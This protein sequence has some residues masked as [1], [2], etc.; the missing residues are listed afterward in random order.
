MI[1]CFV[2]HRGAKRHNYIKCFTM[3]LSIRQRFVT[4]HSFLLLSMAFIIC[5]ATLSRGI[6]QNRPLPFAIL[7]STNPGRISV[8]VMADFFALAC[9]DLV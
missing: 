8:T 7:V 4:I 6:T 1:F 9:K 5:F 2:L 3:K